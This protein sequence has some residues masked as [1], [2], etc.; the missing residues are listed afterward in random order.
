MSQA[1]HSL[2]RDPRDLPWMPLWQR[3]FIRETAHLSLAERGAYATML[4]LAWDMSSCSL[5]ADKRWLMRRL[6]VD[7]QGYRDIVEPV[8]LDFW[9]KENGHWIHP[10]QRRDRAN[11]EASAF[12]NHERA[13]KGAA[14][15][16]NPNRLKSNGSGAASSTLQAGAKLAESESEAEPESLR[17]SHEEEARHEGES[18][19]R[20]RARE[21][22][23]DVDHWRREADDA[24]NPGAW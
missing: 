22:V 24:W 16:H 1:A 6:G 20:A 13:K 11:A 14:A 21:A 23:V 17:P 10:Q 2:S 3:T 8:L 12:V 9:E 19:T 4:A 7:E 18:T 5:L 15:R